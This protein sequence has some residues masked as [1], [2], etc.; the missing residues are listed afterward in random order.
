MIL[1]LVQ[2]GRDMLFFLAEIHPEEKCQ[3]GK[4]PLPLLSLPMNTLTA[5]PPVASLLM[6]TQPR[7]GWF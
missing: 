3:W 6:V 1:L 5:W 7:G 2:F 4:L